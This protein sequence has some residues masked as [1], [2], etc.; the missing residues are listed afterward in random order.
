MPNRHM[1][2]LLPLLVIKEMQNKT[3][4]RYCYILIRFQN[5]HSLLA[6]MWTLVMRG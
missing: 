4:V 3:S 6:W 1:N 2:K 5:Q